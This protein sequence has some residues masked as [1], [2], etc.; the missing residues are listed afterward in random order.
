MLKVGIFKPAQLTP[1]GVDSVMGRRKFIAVDLYSS[2]RADDPNCRYLEERTLER[3]AVANGTFKYTTA[4]RFDEFDRKV[5][6]VIE[7]RFLPTAQQQP[8]RVH[9]VGVSDGRTS[10]AFYEA[11]TRLYEGHIDFTASDMTSFVWA[12]SR[13]GSRNRIIL[14]D[15]GQLLQIIAPPFVFS[16]VRPESTLL[17]PLNAVIRHLL[18]V[19]YARPLQHALKNDAA[20]S[21]RK[22]PLICRECMAFMERGGFSFIDHDLLAPQEGRFHIVRVMNLLNVSYFTNEELSRA[23]ENIFASLEDGGLF[24]TGSNFESGTEVNGAVYRKEKGKAHK[25]LESGSGFVA[26]HHLRL[27]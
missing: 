21:R 22:I 13:P 6:N 12:V 2:V 19:L 25:L 14:D 15:R 18:T 1:R 11:L 17:Y 10:L 16:T 20:L 9:D 4:R 8:L 26:E 23:L 7:R 27:H 5:L 24:I 3:F